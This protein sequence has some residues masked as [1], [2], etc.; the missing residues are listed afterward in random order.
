MERGRIFTLALAMALTACADTHR[1]SVAMK[2]DDREA[3]ICM[4]NDEVRVGDRVALFRDECGGHSVLSRHRRRPSRFSDSVCRRIKLGEGRVVRPLDE[5]CS[6]V[7]VDPGVEIEEGAIV[8][9]L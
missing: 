8:E 3:H 6:V 7:E 5:R 1:G 2:V 4:V 9:K